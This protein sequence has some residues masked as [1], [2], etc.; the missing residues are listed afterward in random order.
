[1]WHKPE[2]QRPVAG[3]GNLV[4]GY[5]FETPLRWE[6]IAKFL[7]ASV[8]VFFSEHAAANN[9]ALHCMCRHHAC[10]TSVAIRFSIDTSPQT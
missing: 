10:M 4:P 2:A 6:I 9:D 8:C 3:Q 5:G 7:E 1:M